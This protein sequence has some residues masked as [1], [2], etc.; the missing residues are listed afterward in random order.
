[1]IFNLLYFHLS[2]HPALQQTWK[3]ASQPQKLWKPSAQQPWGVD[4]LRCS[5][6]DPES[7]HHSTVQELTEDTLFTR[8][9]TICPESE[10]LSRGE[11]LSPGCLSKTI[12]DNHLTVQLP[13][14]VIP[15]EANKMLAEKLER[16]S[17][18]IKYP[19][20][21]GS[22]KFPYIPRDLEGLVYVQVWA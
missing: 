7:C 18:G 16:R 19:Y 14:T 4:Q 5:S 11:V 21:G 9:I 6:E 22:E 2:L 13:E 3:S 15:V 10:L 17:G 8:L 1:M 20:I 12:S